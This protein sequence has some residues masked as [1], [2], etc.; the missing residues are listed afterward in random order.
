MDES[1]LPD[2]G[3]AGSEFIDGL[4]KLLSENGPLGGIFFLG[5]IFIY[6]LPELLRTIFDFCRE[7]RDN[8]RKHIQRMR[9]ID[10]R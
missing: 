1:I 9:E 5:A 6:R 3:D 8:K 2:L 4:S 7:D 10:G